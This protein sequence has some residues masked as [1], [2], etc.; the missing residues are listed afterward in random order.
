MTIFLA[1]VVVGLG[2]YA[3]RAVFILLFA[4]R[5]IPHTL[6]SALQYV[7]PATLSAL[8]VTVLVDDNGQFAVGLAEMTGLG[9]GALVAY[10]TRNHLYTLVVAMG[11]FL[12]LNALL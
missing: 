12:T 3:S 6:Q 10:F 2:T 5:K 7:A 9:L 4:N 11:S 8:I 1:I